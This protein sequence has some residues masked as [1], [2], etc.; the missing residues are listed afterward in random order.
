[1]LKQ[2]LENT[3]DGEQESF[4]VAV[5]LS[6][7]DL[8]L[9]MKVVAYTFQNGVETIE[10]RHPVEH[11]TSTIRPLIQLLCKLGNGLLGIMLKLVDNISQRLWLH[12][13]CLSVS[14]MSSL[15]LVREKYQWSKLLGGRLFNLHVGRCV[16]TMEE[17]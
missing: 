2:D 15:W 12:W 17:E 4:G 6:R 7:L 8:L 16:F 10:N 13:G 3:G 5:E 1:M 9:E 11:V 14:C